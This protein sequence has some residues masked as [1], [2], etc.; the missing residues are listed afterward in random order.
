[1]ADFAQSLVV[2][3]TPPVMA[4]VGAQTG[5]RI[6]C[7]TTCS[8]SWGR[9]HAAFPGRQL[10]SGQVILFKEPLLNVEAALQSP[11]LFG[12]DGSNGACHRCQFRNCLVSKA[13][14]G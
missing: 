10:G 6:K 1:M 7:C 13:A 11:A 8:N 9:V 2:P 5:V 3:T 14:W 12:L 4:P